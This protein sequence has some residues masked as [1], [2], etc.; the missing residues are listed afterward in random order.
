MHKHEYVCMNGYSFYVLYDAWKIFYISQLKHEV[1]S[2][3]FH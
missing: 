3:I 1:Q 2:F